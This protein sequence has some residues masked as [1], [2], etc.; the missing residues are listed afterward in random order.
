MMIAIPSGIQV[1][2]WL[3]TLWG[4]S[5]RFTTSLLYV[6]AF[7]FIFVLG[8]LT[9]VMVASVPFDLQAHDT[10]FVVAHLHYVLIGGSVF[11]LFGGIYHWFPKMTGRM[12][13]ETVGKWSFWL[14][15]IGFN[16]VFFPMHILGLNGMPRRVY[17][18]EA[19]MGWG[20]LNLLI[21]GGA[22]LLAVSVLLFVG[23]VWTSLR[24]GRT[25]GDNPHGD[26]GLEWSTS[27]PPPPYNFENI[28]LVKGR[29]PLWSEGP[30]LTEI[31][32]LR[33]DQREVLVT[34]PLDAKPEH[35]YVLPTHTIW[36]LLCAI[37]ISIGLIGSVFKPMFVYYG[38][39]LSFFA[40]AGWFWPRPSQDALLK[41]SGS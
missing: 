32:G 22:L 41:E 31:R 33:D 29:Y 17:T 14:F 16:V 2:C 38:G 21:L 27:S 25:A 20:N 5:L 8:G 7:F 36:P 3:A 24:S 37:T 28:R 4:G 26:S 12:L 34:D 15:F 11:P 13:N 10:Y 30:E 39:I 35:C 40:F 19:E 1:F 23:N 6:L 18:Y 9:G